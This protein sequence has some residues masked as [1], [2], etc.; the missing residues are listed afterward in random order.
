MPSYHMA[1]G[2]RTDDEAGYPQC[3][4]DPGPAR[5]RGTRSQRGRL[6]AL[7]A[8]RHRGTGQA[9]KRLEVRNRKNDSSSHFKSGKHVIV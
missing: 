7:P 4:E 3:P 9:A 6:G 1:G 2:R 8:A 5:G